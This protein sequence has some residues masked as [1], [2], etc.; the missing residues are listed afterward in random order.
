M[1]VQTTATPKSRVDGNDYLI[2]Y[3]IEAEKTKILTGGIDSKGELKRRF[4]TAAM[5]GDSF[6][7]DAIHY[8]FLDNTQ[9]FSAIGVHTSADDPRFEKAINLGKTVFIFTNGANDM[10]LYGKNVDIMISRYTA[11]IKH[12]RETVTYPRIYIQAILKTS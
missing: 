12:I 7:G 5:I 2:T 9:V 11:C 10:S 1:A 4:A 3:D 6:A 8:V